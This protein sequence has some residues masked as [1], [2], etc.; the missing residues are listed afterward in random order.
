M[1]PQFGVEERGFINGSPDDSGS[2]SSGSRI[3]H[4]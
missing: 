3:F 1:S 4:R 2:Y